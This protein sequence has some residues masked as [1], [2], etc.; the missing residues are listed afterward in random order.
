MKAQRL[1]I[2]RTILGCS[3]AALIALACGEKDPTVIDRTMEANDPDDDDDDDNGG[4]SGNNGGSNGGSGNATN[5]GSSSEGMGG[6]DVVANGGSSGNGGNGGGAPAATCP[7]HPAITEGEGFC[8]LSSSF[9]SP[10][11]TDLTLDKDHVWLLTGPVIIGDD[12][13]ETVL[14][15]EAGTKVFG[16]QLSFILI[17]RSSK[18]IADGTADDPI[19]LTSAQSVGQRSPLDWG[20]LI[21][22]GRAPINRTDNNADDPGSQAGESGTGR[23]GGSV[24]DDNSGVLRYVRVEF[25]GRNIDPENEFNGI[26]FQGVGSETTVDFIQVH[27]VQD[28]GVEFFGGTVNVKHVVVS[29]FNDDGIDWTEGWV[30]KGQFLVA[31]ELIASSNLSSDPR[32][33]EADNIA[34]TTN[35]NEQPFSDPTLSNVTLIGRTG[36]T[37]EGMRLR[38]GTRAEIM[39]SVVSWVGGPCLQLSETQTFTNVTDETLNLTNM[40]FNC[41]APVGGTGDAL[42]NGTTLTTDAN[43]LTTP[44]LLTGATA[45]AVCTADP[46]AFGC[47]VEDVRNFGCWVPGAGSAAL[48]I[49]DVPNGGDT[50]FEVVNY[51]GAFAGA[52]GDWTSGWIETALR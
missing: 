22:N 39:N 26:A 5:G 30:G 36:N 27:M 43:V 6:T 33:I 38:R 42:T 45:E 23:Y 52:E 29:G 9:E 18:I 35:F 7:D 14:T 12:V 4:S 15:I 49:G 47:C 2:L 17:Q 34:G 19:V 21:I 24:A 20:G 50:F 37:L 44:A 32:G 51:A 16:N 31:Q 40:V 1:P 8:E 11:T 28:D 48:A 10:I 25:A 13:E 46:E 3:C 41:T